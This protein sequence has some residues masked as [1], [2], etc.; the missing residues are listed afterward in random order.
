MKANDV[1]EGS[2]T[3]RRRDGDDIICEFNHFKMPYFF[4]HLL[5]RQTQPSRRHLTVKL[6]LMFRFSYMEHRSFYLFW[7]HQ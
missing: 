4:E 6:V 2:G 5:I 3:H 7:N 1:I